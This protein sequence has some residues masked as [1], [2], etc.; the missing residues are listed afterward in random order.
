MKMKKIIK[1]YDTI[2]LDRDGTLN[3]DPG[4]ISSLNDFKFYDFTI[5]AL[6]RMNVYAS[7]FCIIT[8]QSGLARGKIELD[9]LSKINNYILNEFYENDL[10]LVGIYFC[11]DHP[12]EASENRK[13][14][15][16]MFKLAAKEH[17]IDISNS[18]MIGDAVSDIEAGLN[19][20]M[21]TMLVLTGEGETS[22]HNL[23]GLA[24]KLIADN[25]MVGAEI[26]EKL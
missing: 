8:N 24:P 10:N 3:P 11:P 14:G 4:Y 17:D 22:K 5:D 18:I 25:I 23:N 21:D 16:G 26:M 1:K 7:R 13:P 15:T 9:E 19:L 12:D 6:K 2:F 20:N